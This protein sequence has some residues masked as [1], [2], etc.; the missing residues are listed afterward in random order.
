MS[1]VYCQADYL[2]ATVHNLCC[3]STYLPLFLVFRLTLWRKIWPQKQAKSSNI[4]SNED[5]V[6]FYLFCFW[7]VFAEQKY[8]EVTIN[9]LTW[10]TAAA[11]Q[12]KPPDVPLL[13]PTASFLQK[14]TSEF[15]W[16]TCEGTVL[17]SGVATGSG[18]GDGMVQKAKQCRLFSCDAVLLLALFISHDPSQCLTLIYHFVITAA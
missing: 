9:C 16:H 2:N 12:T 6:W 14:W 11:E 15:T 8:F 5:L 3:F 4:G 1:Y 10:K 7:M 18:S 17:R 13:W